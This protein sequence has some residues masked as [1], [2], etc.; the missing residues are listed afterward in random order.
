LERKAYLEL[1]A[2][3]GNPD[4]KPLILQGARQVGKTWLMKEFGAREFGRTA[5]FDFERTRELHAVFGGGYD[6]GQIL[7]ALNILAGFE[8]NPEDTLI[9]FD[10]I[11]SCPEAVT[12]LKYFREERPLQA[13]VAA[14]SLLG[15]AMHT[16][17]SFPVGQVDFMSLHPL[18]YGEFLSAVGQGALLKSLD[19]ADPSFADLFRDPFITWLKRYLFIGGM[20]EAVADYAAHGSFERVRDIQ[21]DVL[22]AYENDFSKHAPVAALPRIRMVWRS[23]VGQL[24]KENAKFVYSLMRTGARAKEFEMALEWLRDA[25]LIH[26]V[27]RISKPGLPVQ[28]YADGSDFKVY[29]NDTGLL[30]AMAGLPASVLLRDDVLFTEFKGRLTEQFVLQQMVCESLQPFYWSPDSGISEV[31]FIVQ[32][33]DRVVPIEVKAATNP[34]SKSLRVYHDKYRPERC[35]RT[36]LL[37]HSRQDWVENIPLYAF[38]HGLSKGLSFG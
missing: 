29:L 25:G 28:A 1:L 6:T 12:S 38:Q 5:Y 8:I 11:Q 15:V 16:G 27:H 4:R 34:R 37:G 36:S 7:S 31:D 21:L 18:G 19:A 23:I 10:E 24:A 26:K 17:F 3:K 2:W 13:V 14:G 9:V 35:V 33:G 20:P 30:C 22:T 32:K